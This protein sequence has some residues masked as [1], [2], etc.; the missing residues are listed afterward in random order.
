MRNVAYRILDIVI[1]FLGM[2]GHWIMRYPNPLLYFLL[3]LGAVFIPYMG[4][5]LVVS[6]LC[7]SYGGY[8]G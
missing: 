2:A 1:R 4:A 7:W 3:I 5:F 6:F 8:H